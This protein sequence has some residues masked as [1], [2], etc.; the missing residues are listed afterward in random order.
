MPVWV[1][2]FASAAIMI[3]IALGFQGVGRASGVASGMGYAV[4]AL[5]L[6]L[7][8]WVLAVFAVV[9]VALLAVLAVGP[10]G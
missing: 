3:G 10:P 5:V 1:P 6:L 2:L 9:V 8:P 7:G 4:S